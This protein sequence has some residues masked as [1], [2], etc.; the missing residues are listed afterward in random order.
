MQVLLPMFNLKGSLDY[1]PEEDWMEDSKGQ[2]SHM[3]FP[4]FFNALFKLADTW[5]MTIGAHDYAN[6][7]LDLLKDAQEL[8][9]SKGTFTK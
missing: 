5:C 4:G 2:H 3:G 9:R 7:L 1:D 6:L 8:E